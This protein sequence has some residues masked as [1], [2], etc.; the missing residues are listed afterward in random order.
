MGGPGSGERGDR[1]T[2]DL[3]ENYLTIDVRHLQR[4][5]L[6]AHGRLFRWKWTREGETV[7]S[8]EVR[9]DVERM[10][11]SY[12]T[13]DGASDDWIAKDYAVRL[14]WTPCHFGGMRPWFLCPVVGCGRRVAILYGPPVF[15]CRR[16]HQLAYRCQRESPYDRAARRAD[17]IR[18]HLDWPPGLWNP[19]GG[20][21]KGMHS[22]TFWRLTAKYEAFAAD[23]VKGLTQE[24]QRLSRFAYQKL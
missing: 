1:G 2:K 10:N 21:R 13:H 12:R 20:R 3:T 15:A 11:L 8:V 22:R 23:A 9:A 16:C 6:L 7:A 4:E 19:K 18:A 5:G 14:E 17:K 24:A